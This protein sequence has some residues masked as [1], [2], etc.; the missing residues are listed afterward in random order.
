MTVK[1]AFDVFRRR[2]LTLFG[3]VLVFGCPSVKSRRENESLVDENKLAVPIPGG[4]SEQKDPIVVHRS[5]SIM[6][7]M[8]LCLSKNASGKTQV[9][10]GKVIIEGM[11]CIFVS[12]SN[13]IG[14]PSTF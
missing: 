8:P 4:G 14:T 12:R 7:V 1:R 3:K 9:T 10:Q 5:Q 13:D 2:M 11:G 6:H